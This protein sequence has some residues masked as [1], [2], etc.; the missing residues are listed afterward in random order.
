ME[1]SGRNAGPAPFLGPGRI[2]SIRKGHVMSVDKQTLR[3]FLGFLAL[4]AAAWLHE[5]QGWLVEAGTMTGTA[6]DIGGV[7]NF[8]KTVE[9]YA[10]GNVGKMVGVVMGMG[11]LGMALTGRMGAGIGVLGSGLGVAFVPNM[12]GTVFDATTAAPVVAA[13]APAT[14]LGTVLHALAQ[15]VAGQALLAALYP[16]ALAL[17][18]VRD[19]V[20]WGSAALV[21]AARSLWT[22]AAVQLRERLHVG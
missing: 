12:M 19:P 2:G 3:Y 16:L 15:S 14:T 7:N 17:K 5:M 4:G 8:A 6:V 11:G 20:V 21:L 13:A 1:T 10:K 9:T 18:W 22:P